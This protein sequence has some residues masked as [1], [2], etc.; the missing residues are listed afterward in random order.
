[1]STSKGCLVGRAA[2]SI[3]AEVGLVTYNTCVFWYDILND[4]V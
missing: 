2:I 4:T 3:Q 1:M